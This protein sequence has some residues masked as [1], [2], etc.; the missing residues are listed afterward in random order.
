MVKPEAV[1]AFERHAAGGAGQ[2]HAGDRHHLLDADAHR[3]LDGFS[4]Q[5]PI[6]SHRHPHRQ[7]AA[8]VVARIDASQ[9]HEGPYQQ[10]RA[11]EQHQR[12]GDLRH[13]EHR[14]RLVLLKAGAGPAAAFLERRVQVRARRVQGRDQ[15]EHQP[16]DDRDGHRERQHAPVERD[17]GAG[18]ADTGE[19]GGVHGE[20]R[21]DARH[22]QRHAKDAAGQREQDAF[23]QQL[24]DDAAAPRADRGTDRNLTL[25]ARRAGQQQV[26][27][28]GARDQQHK[29][30]PRPAGPRAWSGRRRPVPPAAAAR[31]TRCRSQWRSDIAAGTPLPTASAWRWPD[32]A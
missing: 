9:R 28:V 31:Q 27:D 12:Q 25:A 10:R 32:R 19:T 8:G 7:H 20:Q 23:G 4:L 1:A 17:D 18:L 6:A 11:D 16:G 15:A 29:R 22:A 2:L 13:H 21:A 5:V 30:T 14:A 3:L 24:A 26:G